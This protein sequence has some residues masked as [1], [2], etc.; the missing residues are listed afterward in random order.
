MS[1]CV[2]RVPQNRKIMDVCAVWKSGFSRGIGEQSIVA[3]S[4]EICWH[5]FP[6]SI[7]SSPSMNSVSSASTSAVLTRSCTPSTPHRAETSA[8]ASSSGTTRLLTKSTAVRTAGG[9]TALAA[10]RGLPRRLP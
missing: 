9:A 5:H 4:P 7:S 10:L 1:K 2:F 3:M 8:S 6:R